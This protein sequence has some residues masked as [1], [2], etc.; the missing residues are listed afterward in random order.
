MRRVRST[1]RPTPRHAAK[2]WF[3]DPQL[4]VTHSSLEGRGILCHL[5]SRYEPVD[6]IMN[7]AELFRLDSDLVRL[8]PGEALFHTGDVGKE[9]F[10]LIDGNA[11]VM[12]GGTLVEG[13]GP[14]ALLGEMAL[15][16]E[17]PRT[18]TVIAK[19]DCHLARVNQKRFHF[20]VQQNPFFATHVM[21]E[22]VARLRRMN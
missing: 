6:A 20:M 22:L 16:E 13:A 9:M 19:S 8:A 15:I 4:F 11:D 2:R 12:I 17:A 14:G 1:S 3:A 7:P 10:V 21:K 18:A 5:Q